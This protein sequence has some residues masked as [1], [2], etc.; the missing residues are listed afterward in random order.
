MEITE[1][2]YLE[3][4]ALINKTE[5][6]KQLIQQFEEQQR[7]ADNPELEIMEKGK[8]E[9]VEGESIRNSPFLW[10]ATKIK[11]VHAKGTILRTVEYA[12]P[13]ESPDLFKTTSD[14]IELI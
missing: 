8:V 14:Q 1:E 4:L 10:R 11:Y 13:G 3:A 9:F 5:E 2:Q 7:Y 6:A 12:N